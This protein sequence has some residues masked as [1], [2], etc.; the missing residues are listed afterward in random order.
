MSRTPC[1]KRE[2][3]PGV[4][5]GPHGLTSRATPVPLHISVFVA[6]LAGGGLERTMVT[7]A[8]GLARRG[9]RVEL[10]VCRRQGFL[11]DKVPASVR[12]SE[13]RTAPM[14]RARWWAVRADA[15]GVRQLLR[16]FL[17]TRKPPHSLAQ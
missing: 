7:I 10:L 15:G 6:T 14:W 8:D 1:G 5:Q 4:Y 11:A 16:P 3:P 9:H 2:E 17:L 13:L 12:V